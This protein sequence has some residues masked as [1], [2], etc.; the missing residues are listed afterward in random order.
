MKDNGTALAIGAVALLAGASAAAS[1]R[2]G[3]GFRMDSQPGR[4]QRP[5]RPKLPTVEEVRELIDKYR[6]DVDGITDVYPDHVSFPPDP[7]VS[8]VVIDTTGGRFLLQDGSDGVARMTPLRPRRGSAAFG[9]SAAV[10]VGG[11][12]A[13]KLVKGFAKRRMDQYLRADMDEKIEMVRKAA[14]T[15]RKWWDPR[16]KLTRP[17]VRR[18]LSDRGNAE[19]VAGTIDDLLRRHGRDAEAIADVAIASKLK[20]GPALASAIGELETR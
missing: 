16:G 7:S 19:A 6:Y 12:I 14:G 3:S 1:S 13:Y 5:K 4:P 2:S 10:G 11:F 18:F 20:G 17:M 9:A 15:D 8:G